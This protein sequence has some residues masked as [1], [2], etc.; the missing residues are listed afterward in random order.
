MAAIQN[1]QK[2]FGA[3]A[4]DR[5]FITID[6][7]VKAMNIQIMEEVL[8]SNHR[9]IGEILLDQ[10]AISMKQIDEV[11]ENMLTKSN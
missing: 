9:V 11:L 4:V 6:Q 7:L 1:I 3:V 5:G 8:R 2:R 10:G